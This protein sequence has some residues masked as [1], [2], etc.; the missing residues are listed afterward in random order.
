MAGRHGGDARAHLRTV[1]R[2]SF[3][4][5]EE[6]EGWE[7]KRKKGVQQFEENHRRITIVKVR[8]TV[9]AGRE[10][11]RENEKRRFEGQTD[12]NKRLAARAHHPS[13]GHPPAPVEAQKSPTA[14]SGI[15]GEPT[16]SRL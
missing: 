10:I 11:E 14:S 7:R 6:N 2:L 4:G 9:K 1:H 3:R 8:I 12:N 16:V 5:G 13:A 15:S